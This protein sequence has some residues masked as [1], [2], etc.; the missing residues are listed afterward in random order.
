MSVQESFRH[1]PE[2]KV[3]IATDHEPVALNVLSAERQRNMRKI[4]QK[5]GINSVADL[6]KQLRAEGLAILV[7]EHDMEFVMNLA[8]RVSVLDFGQ[9]IAQ[10][11]P[12]EIQQ[13]PA[14]LQAYLGG[15][16]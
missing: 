11:T 8:D 12:K 16:A 5:Y 14:V 2:V 15:V 1:D 4:A 3:L 13:H 7:V 9:M 6:L 10:G